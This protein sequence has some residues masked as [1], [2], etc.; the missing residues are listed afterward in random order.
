[1]KHP[2]LEDSGRKPADN[3]TSGSVSCLIGALQKFGAQ[4]HADEGVAAGIQTC[5]VPS[6]AGETQMH[7]R[8]GGVKAQGGI[9]IAVPVP[10]LISLALVGISRWQ[11]SERETTYGRILKN[12][13]QD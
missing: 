4:K 8:R 5:F 2:D 12:Q 11:G 10:P 1:M 7:I 3:Q 9:H 6:N 13:R